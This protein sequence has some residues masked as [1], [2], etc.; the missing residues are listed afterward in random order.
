MSEFDSR[1]SGY[2]NYAIRLMNIKNSYI[3]VDTVDTEPMPAAAG[4][5][6][7]TEDNN[8]K[9]KTVYGLIIMNEHFVN[10]QLTRY[11]QHKEIGQA[12]T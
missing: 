3:L 1:F 10:N 2:C 12:V 9:A 8:T 4:I 5:G 6:F 7:C 11:L